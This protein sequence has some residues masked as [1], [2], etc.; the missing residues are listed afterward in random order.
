MALLNGMK[1]TTNITVKGGLVMYSKIALIIEV[2]ILLLAVGLV[3]YL[4]GSFTNFTP[5]GLR[6]NSDTLLEQIKNIFGGGD[7]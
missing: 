7:R 4:S 1:N 2:L 5:S 6:D 3:F